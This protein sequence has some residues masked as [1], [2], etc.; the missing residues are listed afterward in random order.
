MKKIN[1][2]PLIIVLAVV[3]GG[4][5]LVI[6][7][8]LALAGERFHFLSGEMSWLEKENQAISVKIG[9]N[10]CLR[11]IQARAEELGLVKADSLVY[12]R[13]EMPIAWKR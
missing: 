11:R 5:Q 9:E 3:L 7:Q 1:L 12:L 2:I 6:S 10:T 8:R 4:V 13:R